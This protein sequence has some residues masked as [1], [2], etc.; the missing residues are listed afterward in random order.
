M[1]IAAR[2]GR[3]GCCEGG[4]QTQTCPAPPPNRAETGMTRED[5]LPT[6]ATPVPSETDL[7]RQQLMR[8]Q[9]L[10]SVGTLASS[11]AHEFNN[12]LTTILNYAKIGLKPTTKEEARIQAFEKIHQ[13]SPRAPVVVN[14]MLGFA[15]N[16][17]S[18]REVTDLVALVEDV[19]VLCEKDLAKHQVHVEK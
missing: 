7:L 14:S 6:A 10:S 15:R 5:M 13:P 9:R 2:M 19:L 1:K 16:Q 11:V 4:A 18:L 3:Y 8:A 12:I 17:T